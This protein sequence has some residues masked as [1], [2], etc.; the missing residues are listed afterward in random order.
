MKTKNLL[1]GKA[2]AL[3]LTLGSNT[4]MA[5]PDGIISIN[6]YKTAAKQELIG[7]YY[8]SCYLGFK[9]MWGTRDGYPEHEAMHGK[10]CTELVHSKNRKSSCMTINYNKY[11][12]IGISHNSGLNYYYVDYDVASIVRSDCSALN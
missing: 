1:I 5:A 8:Q 9:T 7:Y 10:D 3:F 6:Y 11:A 2:V 12:K 4:V